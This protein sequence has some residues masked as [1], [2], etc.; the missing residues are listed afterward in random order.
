MMPAHGGAT[1]GARS[2]VPKEFT[3]CVD[4]FLKAIGN[5]LYDSVRFSWFCA[6]S[7]HTL[8]PGAFHCAAATSQFASCVEELLV[9]TA[10]L[11]AARRQQVHARWFVVHFPNS[12][13]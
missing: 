4:K 2:T 7:E 9:G 11:G 8:A 5:L 1:P 6:G 12:N 3:S 13:F 10:M